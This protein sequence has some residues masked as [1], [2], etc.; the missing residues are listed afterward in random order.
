LVN[1]L[2]L[3][4]KKKKFRDQ[5]PGDQA[6]YPRLALGLFICYSTSPNISKLSIAWLLIFNHSSLSF[7]I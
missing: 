3:S 4:L 2:E 5:E 7:A 1:T 6:I